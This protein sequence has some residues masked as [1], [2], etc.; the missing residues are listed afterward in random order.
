MTTNIYTCD[1]CKNVVLK[2][3]EPVALR[4][5]TFEPVDGYTNHLSVIY[6]GGSFYCP[7]C[8]EWMRIPSQELLHYER[9]V[10]IPDP[11]SD[12]GMIKVRR[13]FQTGLVCKGAEPPVIKPLIQVVA[14]LVKEWKNTH[15]GHNYLMVYNEKVLEVTSCLFCDSE[16][17]KDEY[18]NRQSYL[19]K[20]NKVKKLHVD[21]R[22]KPSILI[23][24]GNCQG[25]FYEDAGKSVFKGGV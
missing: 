3:S 12:T 7:E 5:N 9:D 25:V 19:D 4:R 2:Q 21:A 16:M 6:R 14:D 10:V 18:Y 8:K 22:N 13:K 23:G 17:V 11:N 20:K 24:A 15:A 1:T